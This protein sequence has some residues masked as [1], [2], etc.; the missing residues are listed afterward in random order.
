MSMQKNIK[1][2]IL[3]LA[4]ICV[5]FAFSVSA[6]IK[7]NDISLS[8][9]PKDPG[10]N[11]TVYASIS[12]YMTDLNK[13]F[14]SWTLNGQTVVQGVGQK[15]F[16]FKTGDSGSQT[17]IDVKIDNADG[18]STSKQIVVSPIGI[19]LLWEAYDS[20]VPPFYKGKALLTSEGTVKAVALMN[21]S[22]SSGASYNWKLD[23]TS[24]TDSSG[25]GKN[26]YVFKKS[27]L[28]R[29]NTVEIAASNLLG[30]S[31]GSGKITIANTNPKIVFYKKDPTLGT[32]WGKA[33]EDNFRMD[34]GG[35]T[36][37]FEPY[38]ISPKNLNSS[39]LNLTW[40]LGNSPI[41]TPETK[42]EL[43]IRPESSGGSSKIK[44]SIENIKKMFLSANKEINVNF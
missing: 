35:E 12:S 6:Q 43:N 24:K 3:F 23:D 37:V 16:T 41:A 20:Y 38:F 15:N 42:N 7:S 21:S 34:S 4:L 17:S 9:N 2:L 26:F 8:L 18:S 44:V 30:S 28:D 36:I 39:D 19:D 40:T 25:Y 1:V 10:A 14:I 31:L 33:L 22:K 5:F 13:S 29:N 32:Q 11:E 27:Y